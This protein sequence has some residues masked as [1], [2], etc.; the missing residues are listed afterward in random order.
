MQA[1]PAILSHRD[2]LGVAPTGSGK[3][4]A[5]GIPVLSQLGGPG[6]TGFRACV[7]APTRELS[8]QVGSL[9]WV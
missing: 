2:V 4:L 6:N 8:Q 9:L 7:I 1:I 3:T 5:F